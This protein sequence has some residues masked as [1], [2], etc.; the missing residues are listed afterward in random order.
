[1]IKSKRML[2][3]ALVAALGLTAAA[4]GDDDDEATPET[5]APGDTSAA[6]TPEGTTPD[7]TTAT[8]PEGTTA[9]TPEG[10]TPDGTAPSGEGATIGL[11]F[12]ITGRGDRSFNDAAAAGLDQAVEEFGVI[13]SE[14]TPTGDADRAD[15]LN[16]LVGDGNQLVIGV[17][18]LWEGALEAGAIANPDTHF[19]LVDGVA[20]DPAGTPDDPNDDTDLPNVANLLFAEHEGSF[21][22]GAAAALTSTTGKIGFVGGVEIDLIKKFEAGYIA[23]ATAVNPDI[24]IL[25]NYASQPPDFSGFNAPNVGLE[26][27]TQMY[28]DGADVVYHAAGGTGLGVFQAATEAGAP[29][30]VWAIGVDSDQWQ[31]ADPAQQP[32]ILTSMLKRVDVAVYETI[33]AEAEGAFEPGIQVFDLSVDGVGY[34]TSGDNLSAET[35]AALEDFK[36]QIIAGEIEVPEAP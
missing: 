20:Q 25:S 34:A 17:G 30:E 28:A 8:T 2:A 11:L 35:I 18:F 31:T 4:C 36:A 7:G 27:A 15:R 13:P 12:D 24:E 21:L 16:L 33:K 5:G 23:G 22:V 26:I 14:S 29:G 10:T 6:T 32:Y 3:A 19:A 1:M 9:T